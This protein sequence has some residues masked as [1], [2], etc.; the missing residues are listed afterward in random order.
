MTINWTFW[1]PWIAVFLNIFVSFYWGSR[2]VRAKDAAI[3]NLKQHI[4]NLKDLAPPQLEEYRKATQ[5]EL[6]GY[7]DKLKVELKKETESRKTI[8][9]EI[10]Q[11]QEEG[12]LKQAK[13]NELTNENTNHQE[14]ISRR[15][16]QIRLLDY[17]ISNVLTAEQ[18]KILKHEEAE[19]WEK[20]LNSN[21]Q[22][23]A[24]IEWGLFL[25]VDAK[26][27]EPIDTMT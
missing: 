15:V 4:Q 16:S 9:K 12:G 8:N 3:E 22:T 2:V 23:E 21:D 19:A 6:T 14:K 26:S 10:E 11:L 20:F 13:I 25:P 5:R 1:L 24:E 7:I 17:L 27:G 18:K